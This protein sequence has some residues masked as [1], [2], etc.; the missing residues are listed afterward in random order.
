MNRNVRSEELL[1]LGQS[2]CGVARLY[3]GVRNNILHIFFGLLFST[4]PNSSHV[5]LSESKDHFN[6]KIKRLHLF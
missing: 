5:A 1:H 2:G 3:F 4:D 6:L